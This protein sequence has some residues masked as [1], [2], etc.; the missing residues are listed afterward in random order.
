MRF[1][2]ESPPR[3]IPVTAGLDPRLYRE[4]VGSE[5]AMQGAQ[6]HTLR[7]ILDSTPNSS[8]FLTMEAKARIMSQTRTA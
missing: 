1:A 2:G 6:G 4:A 3:V 8:P 5:N 7:A